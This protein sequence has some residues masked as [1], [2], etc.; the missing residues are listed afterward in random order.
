[1]IDYKKLPIDQMIETLSLANEQYINDGESFLSDPE[2]DE[3][4]HYVE[5]EDPNNPYLNQ[6]LN[7]VGSTTR[8]KKV[9]LPVPMGGITQVHAGQLLDWIN[10][11]GISQE[12]GSIDDKLDG[13]GCLLVYGGGGRFEMGFARGEG[14]A[15]DITR[16]LL[17]M[18]S[19]PKKVSGPMLVRGENIMP[20][21]NLDK[22]NLLIKKRD[23]SRY[24]TLRGL[25]AGVM[26]S[27]EKPNAIYPLIDFV[28]YKAG[29]PNKNSMGKRN[30]VQWLLEQGFKVE[31]PMYMELG[32]I[33]EEK[34]IEYLAIRRESS[35]Y[36]LDGLVI[37]IEDAECSNKINLS[38]KEGAS[39]ELS[40]V[41]FK[42][43]TQTAETT[44]QYI[45]W[46][47]SKYGRSKPTVIYE[48]VTLGEIT[49][50]RANGKNA[51]YIIDNGLG[52]GA[53]IRIVRSGDIVPNN[54][55]VLKS[56][57]P[58][59]PEGDYIWCINL[60]GSIGADLVQRN[61]NG[62]I[63]VIQ[64]Q[65]IDFFSSIN[66]PYLKGGN[67][68]KL[69]E[70]NLDTIEKIIKADKDLLINTIG[71]KGAEIYDSLHLKLN[72]IQLY[73]LMGATSIFGSGMGERKFKKL[74]QQ[75]GVVDI[76]RLTNKDEEL[77]RGASGFAESARI[78]IEQ[79]P[80][81]LEFI[82][83]IKGYF[84]L[85]NDNTQ[86]TLRKGPLANQK[87]VFTGFRNNKLKANVIKLGG[88]ISDS[89]SRKTTLLVASNI[90]N[91]R[92]KIK[93]AKVL[94]VTII[95]LLSFTKNISM[96][97]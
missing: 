9:T 76:L 42:V 58:Q 20:L 56:V 4:Y 69:I 3:L 93:E 32:C 44:I 59:L 95:D 17:K 28:A 19:I 51:R 64:K 43:N 85:A 47:D 86:A 62:N 91:E 12:L 10:D 55:A 41:K 94:G 96:L 88:E 70:D 38:M 7:K 65:I 14:E 92:G 46:N 49:A 54:D 57:T 73:E 53:R 22:A 72:N 71:I 23:G 8:G 6:Q 33:S 81:F 31:V 21:H 30:Q 25:V 82:D 13:V 78:V 87:I 89:V 48:P 60:D 77:V 24:K 74:Q 15:S 16:H 1:M 40:L 61:I 80:I 50:T 45:E 90:N 75:L 29:R 97:M 79:M 26:N 63:T 37:G 67:V 66:I 18:P 11:N 84:K 2:Y 5:L 35:K 68:F 39:E 27:I 34:L 52:P 83:S 36:Q